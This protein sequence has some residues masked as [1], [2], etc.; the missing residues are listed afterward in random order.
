M[1]SFFFIY[2]WTS[3]S[4]FSLSCMFIEKTLLYNYSK[5]K[6]CKVD[7]LS[8]DYG[9]KMGW[10]KEEKKRKGGMMGG[11]KKMSTGRGDDVPTQLWNIICFLGGKLIWKTA[12]VVGKRPIR[13]CLEFKLKWKNDR[14]FLFL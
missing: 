3:S 8:V 13:P 5:H 7:V 4:R 2:G 6:L 1:L 14:V 10:N 12:R 11:M 9:G